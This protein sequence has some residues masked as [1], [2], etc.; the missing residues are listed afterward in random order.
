MQDKGKAW[1]SNFDLLLQKDQDVQ[2]DENH[3]KVEAR[4]HKV[5]ST[6]VPVQ[7]LTRIH[8]STQGRQKTQ[9]QQNK[10]CRC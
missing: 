4:S 5:D 9:Q 1:K 2:S 3:E 6:R 7:S 8:E 10:S